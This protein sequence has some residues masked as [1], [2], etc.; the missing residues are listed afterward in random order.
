MEYADAQRRCANDPAEL[1]RMLR[2]D[3][4]AALYYVLP[5]VDGES[6]RKRLDVEK[7]LPLDDAL[8]IARDAADALG[9]APSFTPAVVRATAS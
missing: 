2:P 4:I 9:Y 1:A 3:G 8:R 5:F 7:Q 6:L